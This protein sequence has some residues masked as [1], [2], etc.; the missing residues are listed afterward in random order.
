[1]DHQP[2]SVKYQ[3][4]KKSLHGCQLHNAPNFDKVFWI[5]FHSKHFINLEMWQHCQCNFRIQFGCQIE[6][7]VFKPSKICIKSSIVKIANPHEANVLVVCMKFKRLEN[8]CL[9]L[10]NHRLLCTDSVQ[11]S[12]SSWKWDFVNFYSEV[13][14][15][16]LKSNVM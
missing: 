2:K 13:K 7:K 15:V 9:K 10:K 4:I 3:S 14:L 16:L 5:T 6:A 11:W 12:K 8:C 1:M